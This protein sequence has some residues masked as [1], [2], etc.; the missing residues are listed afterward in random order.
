[1]K[2]GIGPRSDVGRT[3]GRVV[4]VTRLLSGVPKS[5]GRMGKFE[6]GRESNVLHKVSRAELK[7]SPSEWSGVNGRGRI[8]R[9]G[10]AGKGREI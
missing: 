2:R 8:G 9:M 3:R 5:D 10:E 7:R 6:G 1:M 4:G